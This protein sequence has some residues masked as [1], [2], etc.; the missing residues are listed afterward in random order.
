MKIPDDLS[1]EEKI[2]K[3]KLDNKICLVLACIILP[4]FI[5]LGVFLIILKEPLE[6]GIGFLLSTP[7]SFLLG[8]V[9]PV[10]DNNKKIKQLECQLF[11]DNFKN[12]Q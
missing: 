10:R 12:K 11:I 7:V 8:Y 9:L 5:G 4:I 2:K 6:L 1:K 3:L